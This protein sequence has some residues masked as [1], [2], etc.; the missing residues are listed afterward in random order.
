NFD[1]CDI[2]NSFFHGIFTAS[3]EWFINYDAGSISGISDFPPPRIDFQNEDPYHIPNTGDGITLA[4]SENELTV[5]EG[6]E[7]RNNVQVG[8]HIHENGG[9]ADWNEVTVTGASRLGANGH[10][11]LE[12]ENGQDNTLINVNGASEID[13]NNHGIAFTNTS[14]NEVTVSA[15]SEIF[16]NDNYGVYF[17]GGQENEFH[18]N[19]CDIYDQ[20]EGIHLSTSDLNLVDLQNGTLVRDHT[21]RG[22]GVS[23]SDENI[24]QVGTVTGDCEIADN[25]GEG[26][27]LY[28]SDQ[29]TVTI[30][31][32]SIITNNRDSGILVEGYINNDPERRESIGNTINVIGNSDVIH[33][34]WSGENPRLESGIKLLI[35]RETFVTVDE[36]S[37]IDDNGDHGIHG[38]GCIQ[39]TIVV[40]GA[41]HTDTNQNSGIKITGFELSEALHISRFCQVSVSEQSFASNNLGDG[42]NVTD[43]GG[44]VMI[45]DQNTII[46]DN[47]QVSTNG[48]VEEGDGG[49]GVKNYA[50]MEDPWTFCTTIVRNNSTINNNG[51]TGICCVQS[52]L[53]QVESSNVQG[54]GHNGIHV[55]KPGLIDQNDGDPGNDLIELIVSISSDSNIGGA[56]ALGNTDDGIVIDG[57][58]L[59]CNTFNVS[60]SETSVE[61]S[62]GR[63]LYIVDCEFVG[64][65]PPRPAPKVLI[66]KSHFIDNESDFIV[67][68][69]LDLDIVVQG[70]EF[71]GSDDGI[72]IDGGQLIS[73]EVNAAV[74]GVLSTFNDVSGTG[75]FVNA[76]EGDPIGLYIDQVEFTNI[77]NK[78]KIEIDLVLDNLDTNSLVLINKFS[79]LIFD[80][81]KL[82]SNR[83]S[84]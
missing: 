7:I 38:L 70:C 74:G 20:P 1:N 59:D 23:L 6:C 72:L 83:L 39:D 24:I 40:Q 80:R 64:V 75:I 15:G 63:G 43:D 9:D 48:V 46:I 54:N 18:G 66:T 33:N 25:T 29:N 30:D 52:K 41:S 44:V 22:I 82:S 8:I 50:H 78:I 31:G 51:H 2:S 14:D 37:N 17:K 36:T 58:E 73:L 84:Q 62:G 56:D 27:R 65:M 10:A 69:G 71:D 13:H 12:I 34:G 45:G 16:E 21:N 76:D 49:Y 35:T 57:D 77:I 26:I 47:S 79:S 61:N 81:Y 32:A 68:S 53:L 67:E 3:D 42:G 28:L 55:V 19:N 5:D 4:S 60:L 11:G